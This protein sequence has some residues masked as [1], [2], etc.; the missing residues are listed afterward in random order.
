MHRSAPIARIIALKFLPIKRQ[1][2]V[3]YVDNCHCPRRTCFSRCVHTRH[4][5]VTWLPSV[6][7]RSPLSARSDKI[8]YTQFQQSVPAN[9]RA[10]LGHAHVM[11]PCFAPWERRTPLVSRPFCVRIAPKLY[12]VTGVYVC[13]H[14]PSFSSCPRAFEMCPL[15][16]CQVPQPSVSP[17][18]GQKL[19]GV[20]NSFPSNGA[21]E[22]CRQS[23]YAFSASRLDR[24][25][26]QISTQ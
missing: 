17:Q 3:A 24:N 6:E 8:E 5:G 7:P 9:Q 20:V 21:H 13:S 15:Y 12:A 4:F 2:L 10:P 22:Y 16:E 23:S 25:P 1:E 19:T 26:G 14:T 18:G 11:H